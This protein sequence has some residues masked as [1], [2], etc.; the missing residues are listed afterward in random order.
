MMFPL[1]DNAAGHGSDTNRR[2]SDY[3]IAC[4]QRCKSNGRFQAAAESLSASE[5]LSRA[6]ARTSRSATSAGSFSIGRT[7]DIG[8]QRLGRAER[9]TGLRKAALSRARRQSWR[10]PRFPPLVP[11]TNGICFIPL[12]KS[13]S[14]GKNARSYVMTQIEA[15]DARFPAP[16]AMILKRVAYFRTNS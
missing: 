7:S 6:A 5:I 16:P 14:S 12:S 9:M 1:P 10:K 11:Q 13:I 2:P 3:Q 15:G 8:H 4:W